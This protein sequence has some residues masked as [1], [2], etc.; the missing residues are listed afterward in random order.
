MKKM[1]TI[2]GNSW[3]LYINKSLINLMD[4]T[5]CDYTVAIFFCNE[6]IRIQKASNIGNISDTYLSKKLIKR[7]SSYGLIF[8]KTILSL[9]NINPEVDYLEISINKTSLLIKKSL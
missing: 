8:D 3:T 9:L 5:D 7:N 2:N 4:I 1:L 6:S